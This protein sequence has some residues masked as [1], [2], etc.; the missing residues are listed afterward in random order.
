MLIRISFSTVREYPKKV[1]AITPHWSPY[2]ATALSIDSHQGS[3]LL[4]QLH[5]VLVVEHVRLAH[6]AWVVLHTRAPYERVL[7]LAE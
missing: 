5:D 2:L 6:D 3:I 7:E 1:Q 4:D